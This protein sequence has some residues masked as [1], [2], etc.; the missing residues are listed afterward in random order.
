[1]RS[2]LLAGVVLGS[3][4]VLAAGT[5]AVLDA[6]DDLAESQ[7]LVDRAEM[8]K[9]SIALTHAL[10]DERDAMVE[11]VAAGRT[12]R[13]GAGVTEAQR[14]RV[15][16]H[17]TELRE[18]APPQVRRA[19]AEL[20]RIRQR[21]Q[22]GG[23]SAQDMYEAYTG[24]ITSLQDLSAGV[25]RSLPA[26]AQAGTGPSGATGTAQALPAL[27]RA[28]EQA[29]STRGLLR[30]ALVGNGTQPG[31]TAQAQRA[32]VR[33][34]AALADF[35]E[36]AGE[37]ARD[38]YAKTVTGA[39]VALAERYLKRL[40]DQPYLSPADRTRAASAP[41]PRSPRGSTACA[42]SNRPSRPMSCGGWSGC[43]TTM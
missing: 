37:I 15:D 10:A 17:V 26:R 29:S 7:R 1:M 43:A 36:A 42:A 20:P 27:G 8:D 12:S 23:S 4:A 31:L 3:L 25:A 40:T 39:D 41:T 6:S 19:I 18:T 30:G 16:R 33:E 9:R 5:P 28:V 14:A 22:G 21:A 32:N 35:D 24:T 38:S 11:Y 13:D 34:Q 2:R